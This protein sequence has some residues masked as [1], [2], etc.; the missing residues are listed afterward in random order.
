MIQKD[1]GR[2]DGTFVDNVREGEGTYIWPDG[3]GKYEGQW[4]DGKRN[5]QGKMTWQ[6]QQ[7]FEGEWEE[8]KILKGR[9]TD[10]DGLIHEVDLT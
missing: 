9:L 8:G 6:D 7:V 4:R 10:A 3:K 1:N 5:G 2:Y